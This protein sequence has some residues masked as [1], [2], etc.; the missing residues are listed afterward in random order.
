MTMTMSTP[1]DP[2][3]TAARTQSIAADLAAVEWITDGRV[4]RT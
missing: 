1:F 4:E 3:Q 2:A